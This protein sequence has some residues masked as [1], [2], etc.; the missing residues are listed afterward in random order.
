MFCFISILGPF[1]DYRLDRS[2]WAYIAGE[3]VHMDH[4]EN[5]RLDEDRRRIEK[6][7]L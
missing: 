7:Q 4:M 2:G 5:P 1:F 3:A 6:A